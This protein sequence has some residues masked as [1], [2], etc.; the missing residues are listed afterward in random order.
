MYLAGMAPAMLSLLTDLVLTS[1]GESP[2]KS[3][4]ISSGFDDKTQQG[5]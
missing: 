1:S 4:I 3:L 2:V 5:N